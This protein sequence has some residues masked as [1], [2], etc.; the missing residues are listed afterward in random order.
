VVDA[1]RARPRMVGT[2]VALLMVVVGGWMVICAELGIGWG[3]GSVYSR[4]P[5][6][7]NYSNARRV[8][9]APAEIQRS[10]WRE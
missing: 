1:L 8:M 2:T 6:N 5:S 9:P 4:A 7:C 10:D 3:G